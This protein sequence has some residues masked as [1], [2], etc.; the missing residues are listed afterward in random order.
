M[1]PIEPFQNQI[2][3][4]ILFCKHQSRNLVWFIL[5]KA[6]ASRSEPPKS[7][8]GEKSEHAP[9]WILRPPEQIPD[10]SRLLALPPV[11]RWLIVA[12][13]WLPIGTYGGMRS[14]QIITLGPFR[15]DPEH[16]IRYLLWESLKS[17]LI[18]ITGVIASRSTS[19]VDGLSLLLSQWCRIRMGW[20]GSGERKQQLLVGA[21]QCGRVK[22]DDPVLD[23]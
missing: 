16:L 9:K 7:I 13:E 8:L 6:C 1:A 4:L 15:T 17:G 18:W 22:H 12:K 10:P 21:F 14:V 23:F 11:A 20:D 2:S 3:R 19:R 5:P